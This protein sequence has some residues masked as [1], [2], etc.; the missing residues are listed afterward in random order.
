MNGLIRDVRYAAVVLRR[1]R[2]FAVVA[3]LALALGIGATTAVFSVIYGV[4]LR[5]LPYPEAERL[6]QIYE[7]HPG[8]PKPPGDLEASSTTLNAWQGRLGTLEA[9]ASYYALDYT[10]T[11]ADGPVRMHGGQVAPAVFT[12]LRERPQ[13]GRFFLPGED[14][15]RGN[16]FVVISDR[17]W[18]ERLSASPDAVGRSLT[19]DGK[20]HLIVGIARP[21]FHFPD[22]DAQLWTL[23]DDPTRLDPSYQGGVWLS[24]AIGRLKPGVTPEQAEAE[25]TAAARAV[26]RPPVLNLLYGVGGPVQVHVVPLAKEMTT[27]IRP[28]LLVV[29]GA[30]AFILLIACANVAN[31]FMTRGVARQREF[32][33][34]AALGA[35]RLRLVRQLLA[36]SSLLAIGGASLGLALAWMLIRLAV[37]GAPADFPRM[38]DVHFDAAVALFAAVVTAATA[39]ATGLLPAIRGTSF[40]L[41]ASLHGSDGATAGGFRGARARRLRDLLLVLEAAVATILIVGAAL[42]GRSFASLTAVDTGYRAGNVLLAQV[43]PAPD[44]EPSHIGAF[45]STLLARLRGTPG[46]V[47]AGAG[48]MVPFSESTFVTALDLPPADGRGQPTRARLWSYEVT[49]GYAEALGLHLR[50]GRFF[51]QGDEQPGRSPVIVNEE[52][53]H[54][55]LAGVDP[56]GHSLP[57]GRY[58]R[59][60]TAT[61]VGV[62]GNMLKDGAD[63]APVPEIYTV[64]RGDLPLGYEIDLVVRTAGD[65]STAAAALRQLVR[66]IDPSMVVGTTRPLADR[67]RASYAQ[68]RFAAAVIAAF[69]ALALVLGGIGL[70]G[71][72]SFAV[73]Q[74]RRELGVRAALGADRRR[75]MTLVVREGLVL[76]LGGLVLGMFGAALLGRTV[77]GILFGI[78]PLDVLSFA[79]APLVLLPVAA[80]ACLIPAHRAADSD[81]AAVLRG[82]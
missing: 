75:L 31:L 51:D 4:L 6:V 82:D 32:A 54:R 9:L 55:F 30:V 37:V 40:T 42:F 53:V 11:L 56:L 79:A 68:P 65:P 1:D 72:L 17:L 18:R 63:K 43:I 41:S 45:T 62:V 39:I 52:F 61:I 10:V 46:V 59:N 5:P 21:E 24:L 35:S 48:N 66:D 50:S 64:S 22:Q 58:G 13:A 16:L 47:A 76:S 29:G 77:R 78:T 60:T 7:E 8:A 69:G 3:L 20:P 26:P 80:L 2:V 27:Q 57:G 70:F 71:V 73:R 33:L 34:R 38:Q 14:A 23:Y 25:G 15:P 67:L 44:A 49:A 36:E 19:I 74:R 12:L 28:V 81:P